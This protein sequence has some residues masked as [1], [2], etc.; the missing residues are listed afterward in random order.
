MTRSHR[1]K[2]I[3]PKFGADITWYTMSHRENAPM[4]AKILSKFLEPIYII[5][6]TLTITLL[7]QCLSISMCDCVSV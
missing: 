2:D 3:V 1:G 4:D 5:T 6:L 7:F